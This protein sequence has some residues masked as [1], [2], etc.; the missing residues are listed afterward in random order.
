MLLRSALCCPSTTA[1]AMSAMRRERA[2]PTFSDLELIVIDDGRR[3]KAFGAGAIRDGP[4]TLLAH[5]KSR[6]CGNL[7]PRNRDARGGISRVK[8]RDFLH[9]QRLERQV[10]FLRFSRLRVGRKLRQDLERKSA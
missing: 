2:V 9:P 10:R 1:H 4:V 3:T 5:A 8:T 6:A 7:E